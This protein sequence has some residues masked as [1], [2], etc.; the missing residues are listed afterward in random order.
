[1]LLFRGQANCSQCRLPH[2]DTF[3]STSQTCTNSTNKLTFNVY[4]QTTFQIRHAPS[5]MTLMIQVR[6]N[7]VKMIG[8]V[9]KS[10]SV[11]VVT[12]YYLKLAA[13]PHIKH[14]GCSAM[15]PIPQQ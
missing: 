13:L 10:I 14:A 11:A 5:I 6:A 7:S 4:P 1:V 3:S 12:L 2:V 15:A 9:D 8:G